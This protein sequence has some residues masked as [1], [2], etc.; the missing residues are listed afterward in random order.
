MLQIGDYV[1]KANYG[2]CRIDGIQTEK[3]SDQLIDYFVLIPLK[4][5]GAQILIPVNRANQSLRKAMDEE[6]A[7]VFIRSIKNIHETY[8]END[9]ARESIYKEALISCEPEKLVGIIKTLY[10]RKKERLE[11]GKKSTELDE[12]YFKLVESCLHSELAFAL[13]MEKEDVK[14]LI[15]KTIE[16][17]K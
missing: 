14:E 1:V 13:Q 12:R 8:I 3:I 9:R 16:E 2:V 15:I 10:L 7:L 17:E 5:K 6:Q 4:E 11:S